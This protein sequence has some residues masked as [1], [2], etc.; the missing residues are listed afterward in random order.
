M[1][2]QQ[3]GGGGFGGGGYGRPQIQIGGPL[4]PIVKGFLIAN[5]VVFLL[6]SL[7]SQQYRAEFFQMFGL[8][9]EL[10]WSQFRVWQLV[11][12]NFLH[13]GFMH[14]LFNMFA[15]WMFGGDLERLYGRKRFLIFL[16]ITGVGAGL[17][18]AVFNPN[19]LIPVVGASGIVYGILLA[20]GL[21][22]PNRKLYVYFLFPI[23]V[24]YFVMILGGL[25]LLLTVQSSNSGV[26]HLAHLGGM[27]FGFL[28]L[29]Y[30]RLYMKLREKYYRRK[31]DKL[32]KRYTV[33][34][35]KDDDDND[36]ITYH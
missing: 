9:P 30:D 24:K 10:F 34:V 15:F 28:Y 33:I 36:H 4:T 2:Y 7:L 26:A 17:T 11:T 23:K 1:A 14:I 18:F 20:Y 8:V 19:A 12:F 27:V 35:N 21:T 16:A 13:A 6:T 29:R 32:K 5:G 3:R 22:Y 31:L 25:E